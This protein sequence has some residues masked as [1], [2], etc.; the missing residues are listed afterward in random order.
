MVDTQVMASA[1]LLV[2]LLSE[3]VYAV[4]FK[5]CFAFHV[6]RRHVKEFHVL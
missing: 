1:C 3:V 2:L 6:W 4:L 5:N